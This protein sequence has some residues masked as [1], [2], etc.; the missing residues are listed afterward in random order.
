MERIKSP[1]VLVSANPSTV[2]HEQ[3]LRLIK[4]CSPF[5]CATNA[6]DAAIISTLW[7]ACAAASAPTSRWTT[8]TVDGMRVLIPTSKTGKPRRAPLDQRAAQ[9]LARWIA[10]R[11]TFP[12]DG[13]TALWV[14]RKGKPAPRRRPPGDRAPQPGVRRHRRIDALVPPWLVC[15]RRV[16]SGVDHADH[17]RQVQP[18]AYVSR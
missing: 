16:G 13:G 3:V 1:K 9:H 6:R 11:A 8:S 5:R 18:E 12:V 10:K 7:A 2:T 17:A 15:G 14:G 4:A